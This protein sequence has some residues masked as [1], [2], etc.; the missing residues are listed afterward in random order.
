MLAA[1][2]HVGTQNCT[3]VMK[4]YTHSRNKEGIYYHNIDKTWQKLML[5]ARVIAAIDSKK[6]V[7]IASSRPYAQRA[8]LKYGLHSGAQYLGGKWTPGTLTN[9]NTKKFIEPR[10]LIVVCP[11]N[12]HQA[13]VEASYM[14]IPTI[15]LCDTDSPLEFVDVAIPC[16]NKSRES[17]ALMIYMLCREVLHL[18]GEISRDEEWET[19]V[20]LFMHRDIEEK[21]DAEEAEE[22]EQEQENQEGGDEGHVQETMKKFEG[23][24]EEQDADDDEDEED[25]AWT[26]DKQE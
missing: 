14:N 15:A 18:R 1:S 19:M 11:R 5:A 16:N 6:D 20:D 26:G 2:V 21:K 9:Q 23:E 25:K 24:G 4:N 17:I 13:L 10:L 12:D 8:V 7:L 3:K 22:Q